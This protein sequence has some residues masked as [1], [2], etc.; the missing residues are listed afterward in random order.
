MPKS[1]VVHLFEKEEK[2]EEK[3]SVECYKEKRTEIHIML[4]RDAM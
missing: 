4:N 1:S 3:K 2:L